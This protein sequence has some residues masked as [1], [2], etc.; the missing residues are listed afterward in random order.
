ML[1]LT[2]GVGDRFVIDNEITVKILAIQDKQ[3]RV[4]ISAPENVKI[5]RG[6]IYDRF[7][8][9]NKTRREGPKNE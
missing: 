2:R 3:V 4:G 1:I 6:E 5:I 8:K 9:K 7:L